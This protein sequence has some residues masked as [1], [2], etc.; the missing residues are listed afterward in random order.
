MKHILL[1]MCLIAGALKGFSQDSTRQVTHYNFSVAECVDYAYA[2]QDSVVNATLDTRSA[3]FKVKQTIGQGLPQISGKANF[4]D[5][6]QTPTFIIGGQKFSIYQPYNTSAAIN[7]SQLLFD[8][9][10]FV[11]LKA[12]KTYK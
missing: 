4:Q 6:L 8:G 1:I 3:E 11:G 10:Y 9:S 7:V 5:Y 12:A 2:H